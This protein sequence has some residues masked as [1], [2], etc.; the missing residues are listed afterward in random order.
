MHKLIP[1]ILAPAGNYQSFLAAVENGADAVYLG[2]SDF[3]ARCQAGNFSE[4]ELQ[5]AL[6]YAHV[7]SRKVYV[8]MNVL[9][10]D[11]EMEPALD[12]AFRLQEMG[13]DALIVQDWGFLGTV[14]CIFD[15]MKLH[16]STQMTLHNADGV[17]ALREMGVDRVILARELSRED[18]ED[19]RQR[20]PEAELEVFVHG[21]LCFS[22]SGQCLLS[23]VVGGRSGNRGRCA[24]PCRWPYQM[25]NPKA[26]LAAGHL[27]SPADLNLL[28]Q[29]PEL[30]RLGMAA[31]KIEGRM[32]R[33]EYVAVVT[34]VYRRC[35][36]QIAEIMAGGGDVSRWTPT[37]QDMEELQAVFNRSFTLNQWY[38]KNLEVLQSRSPGNQGVVVGRVSNVGPTGPW[39]LLEKSLRRGDGIEIATWDEPHPATIIEDIGSEVW[40]PG[41]ELLLSIKGAFH[42]GDPVIRTHDHLLMEDSMAAIRENRPENQ[43][44]VKIQAAARMGRPLQLNFMDES[45]NSGSAVSD[46]ML[47]PAER[48]QVSSDDLKDKLGRLGNTPFKVESWDLDVEPG[49]MVPFSE[50]NEQRRAAA[51]RLLEA[52]L[53]SVR[54]ESISRDEYLGRKAGC[55]GPVGAVK[56]SGP[57][58]ISIRVNSA[59]AAKE[60]FKAGAGRVYISTLGFFG[61]Q[62][63][64]LM[65]A[66]LQAESRR[67]QAEL[68]VEIPAILRSRDPFDWE[69]LGDAGMLVGNPGALRR[70]RQMKSHIQVD[71]PW[72]IFNSRTIGLLARWGVQ[73]AALSP[74]LDL[75]RLK[76]ID[77][78]LLPLEY[79]VHGQLPVMSTE[80][81]IPGNHGMCGAECHNPG[82]QLVDGRG[83]VFPLATDRYCRMHLFNSRTTCLI[84]E[85]PILVKLGIRWLR[86]EAMLDDPGQVGQIVAAY[87]ETL[88]EGAHQRGRLR[89]LKDRLESRSSSPF[90]ALHFRR[91]VQ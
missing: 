70:A 12:Y 81:C 71:Y 35:L 65:L 48:R 64:P 60:S 58:G 88:E 32:K 84:E 26:T 43:I 72:N 34:R 78:S 62:L 91:G 17:M 74:E 50:L 37:S 53:E 54:P 85:V 6:D 22:Y 16:A 42:A 40:E 49:V 20:C 67:H 13:V 5:R 61:E 10:A 19:I 14:A 68:L 89:E 7:R 79:V 36:D 21:A 28:T 18:L 51:G 90:T 56:T 73:G 44:P 86:I 29:L 77:F 30:V 52:R 9:L 4:E 59:A 33:P 46:F 39:I 82:W 47:G 76:N 55:L 87:R 66:E 3:N 1:E 27:M 83:Y 23:S 25:R 15:K 8:T 63:S 31:L 2:G 45:G 24:Q 80:Q 11:Q 75:S 69:G 38:G 57:V 41:R